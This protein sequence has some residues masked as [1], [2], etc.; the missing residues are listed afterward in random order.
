MGVNSHLSPSPQREAP[1]I[2]VTEV[3]T[4]RLEPLTCDTPPASGPRAWASAVSV[5]AVSMQ[6]K[7][8]NLV[9]NWGMDQLEQGGSCTSS[10]MN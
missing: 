7:C 1:I 10:T 6:L 8:I 3:P 2:D 4:Q 9:Q 5:W